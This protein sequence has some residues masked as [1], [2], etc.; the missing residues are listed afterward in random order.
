MSSFTVS[1]RG[2]GGGSENKQTKKTKQKHEWESPTFNEG[3][4]TPCS[5]V[6]FSDTYVW[7]VVCC[8]QAF[9]SIILFCL[10][11]SIK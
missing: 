6:Y 3:K 2:G 4:Q 7:Y 8:F 1:L 11:H 9:G 10:N 5:M